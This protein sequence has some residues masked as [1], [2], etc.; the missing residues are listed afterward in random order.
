MGESLFQTRHP[1]LDRLYTIWRLLRADNRS[2]LASAADPDLLREWQD[3]LVILEA[4]KTSGALRELHVG[5]KLASSVA[6]CD[7]I[8]AAITEVS[9]SHRP[10]LVED[11]I[12]QNERYTALLLPFCEAC[13][14]VVRVMVAIYQAP[15][16]SNDRTAEPARARKAEEKRH[17]PE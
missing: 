10:I 8:R 13:D 17:V 5:D 1:A 12:G 6:S 11:S 15:Q 4:N 16:V 2:P 14:G 9:N 3:H 7:T